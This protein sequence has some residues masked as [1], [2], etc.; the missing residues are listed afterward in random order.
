[1]STYLYDEALTEKIKKWTSK[2]QIE[3]YGPSETSRVFEVI[4]D[5]TD[6]EPIKLPMIYIE[7]DRGFE[8]INSGQTRRP[9]SYDGVTF[10]IDSK[11]G[12]TL[13][14][15]PISIAYQINI[16]ARYAKEADILVRN[17]IFNVINYP[18]LEVTVPKVGVYKYDKATGTETTEPFVHTARIELANT[19]IQ[20]NS[21]ESQRFI[22]GNYTKLSLLIQ[23]NDAYLWDLREHRTAEIEI[24][25]DVHDIKSYYGEKRTDI[26]LYIE[27]LNCIKDYYIFE[28]Y[29]KTSDY[30]LSITPF[31]GDYK[32][33]YYNKLLGPNITDLFR[34]YNEKE[35]TTKIKKI[36]NNFNIIKLS[37]TTP[38]LL[39]FKYIKEN[40]MDHIKDGK[41]ITTFINF[42]EI[43]DNTL[44]YTNSFYKKYK[45]YFG[46]FGEN[47]IYNFTEVSFSERYG[48]TKKITNKEYN[49]SSYVTTIYHDISY[50]HNSF[51]CEGEDYGA[52]LKIYLISNDFYINV[53]EGKTEL[54]KESKA[55]AFK[56]RK[57]IIFDY[58]IFKAYS[59][60]K[61]I[62]ISCK[63]ELKII[64][65]KDINNNNVMVAINEVNI[66]KQNEIYLRFSNPYDKYNSR[67]NEEDFIYL[68][69]NFDNNQDNNNTLYIDIRYYHNNSII[70][71]EQSKPKIILNGNE[72]KIFGDKNIYEKNKLL[73]NLYKCNEINYYLRTYYE[74]NENLISEEVIFNKNNFLLHDNIFNN[75]K[76][77][78]FSNNSQKTSIENNSN[79][80]KL[81]SYYE[82]GDIYMNYF[83][84]NESLY[85]SIKFTN[86]Y[87]IFYE[88]KHYN[89]ILFNWKDFIENKE[90]INNLQI[91]YSLYILPIY[92]PIKTICQ[93]SLI[94]PNISIINKNNYEIN[95]PK[96]DYKIGIIAS[97]VNKEFPLI[98]FYDFSNISVSVRID[99][100]LKII[101][102]ISSFL[103][104]VGIAICCYCKKKIKEKD[105]MEEMQFARKSRMISMANFFEY[106]DEHEIILNDDSEKK[107]ENNE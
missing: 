34:P 16:Y 4:A 57:D 10:N 99:I 68:L 42:F 49:K 88:D 93:M 9:L 53:I 26:S 98:N 91:N 6:D 52:Y 33:V 89:K 80:L 63:Y 100:I 12:D 47:E 96:G 23:I 83:P 25:M 77:I 45:F 70:N 90:I 60:N 41:E 50:T 13:N 95:L 101:I 51:G 21:N 65:P 14:A 84:L 44:I 48:S 39:K 31:Y 87:N 2:A 85:N 19:T 97:I 69:A 8:I 94:P 62:L 107:T 74:N 59:N 104:I 92:S 78:V 5:K 103:L 18:A 64:E 79:S 27:R 72:Y 55:I 43:C 102:P 58:F 37:C 73:L 11:Y 36:T 24:L 76:I 40:Y 54:N 35:I 22:E 82:S 17:F 38:T 30:H 86:N 71:L 7:R 3:V 61:S 1:M 32:M 29:E 75:T 66:E 46:L 20:D 106:S 15:I 105:L 81:A 67:I 56:L 28:T